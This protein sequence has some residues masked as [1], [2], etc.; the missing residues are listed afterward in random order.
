VELIVRLAKDN[1]RW[2]YLRIK[3]ELAKLGVVV[4]RRSSKVALF[5][6]RKSR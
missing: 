1:P 4:C 5:A 6:H 3:G 2:G